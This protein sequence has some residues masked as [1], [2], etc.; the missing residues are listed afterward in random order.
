MTS[1][2]VNDDESLTGQIPVLPS[3]V[4]QLATNLICMAFCR[5]G[6]LRHFLEDDLVVVVSGK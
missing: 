6:A 1:L 2:I 4:R 5:Y 3:V